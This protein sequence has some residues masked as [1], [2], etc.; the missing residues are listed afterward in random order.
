MMLPEAV[1]LAVHFR[2]SRTDVWRDSRWLSPF[3]SEYLIRPL[4]D[5]VY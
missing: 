3:H 2:P 1:K 4:Y 5:G